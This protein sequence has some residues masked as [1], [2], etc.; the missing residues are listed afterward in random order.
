MSC[1]IVPRGAYFAW[2]LVVEPAVGP[3]VVVVDVGGDHLRGLVEGLELVS[4]DAALFKVAKPALDER[5]RFG[6]AL[7]AASVRDAKRADCEPC[8]AGREGRPV[9]R[10]QR[11]RAGQDLLL[12]DGLL[13]HSGRLG[14]AAA[15][16]Q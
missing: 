15:Q 3:V 12:V 8:G 13:D 10:A 16:L 6:V 1:R 11:E 7:A 5:L 9:V 4:P 2:R 14:G